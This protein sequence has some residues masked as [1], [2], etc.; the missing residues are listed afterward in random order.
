MR[1]LWF[2]F[3]LSLTACST[4]ANMHPMLLTGNVD[5][6][7]DVIFCQL[8]CRPIC[9][10]CRRCQPL[11]HAIFLAECFWHVVGRY[12]NVMMTNIVLKNRQQT[13]QRSSLSLETELCLI[14]RAV[15]SRD[16]PIIS[17]D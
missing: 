8:T 9:R 12:Q 16:A 11:S 13:K 14:V 1:P 3:S 5:R 15:N 17:I 2:K 4:G 7:F 10:G 6:Y